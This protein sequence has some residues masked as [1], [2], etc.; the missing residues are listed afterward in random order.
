[1]LTENK[2]NFTL[3]KNKTPYLFSTF[4]FYTNDNNDSLSIYNIK[5]SSNLLSNC[6]F[7]TKNEKIINLFYDSL[8]RILIIA[9][10]NSNLYF[11]FPSIYKVVKQ[12]ECILRCVYY[13]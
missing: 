4:A 2:E 9:T 10:N 13:E 1:M 11:A 12:E 6:Y 3:F 5:N 7:K 8:L